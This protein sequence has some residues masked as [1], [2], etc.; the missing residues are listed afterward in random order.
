[1]LHLQRISKV[2]IRL[3]LF[4]LLIQ[5]AAPA[6]A[7]VGSTDNLIHEK[8]S[9]KSHQVSGVT[10]NILLNENSEEN[11]EAQSKANFNHR[12]IDFS[13]HEIVLNQSHAQIFS[14]HGN[15]ET[16]PKPLFMLFCVFLI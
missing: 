5:F 13:S 12:L 10:L 2:L 3:T 9:L 14:D 8:N 16:V 15:N 11:N 6:F 1:M 4:L 7:N